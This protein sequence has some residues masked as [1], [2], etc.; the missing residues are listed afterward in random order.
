MMLR[1]VLSVCVVCLRACMRC[2]V[3]YDP[4]SIYL[5]WRKVLIPIRFGSVLS[6]IG[7]GVGSLKQQ[8]STW[9]SLF[10]PCERVTK[11]WEM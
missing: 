2:I 9:V 6:L 5:E 11:Y 4:P 3:Y 7:K 10:F 1:H 8:S